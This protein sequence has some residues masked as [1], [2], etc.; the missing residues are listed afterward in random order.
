MVSFRAFLFREAGKV[1][2]GLAWLM[3]GLSLFSDIS[4]DRG[5]WCLL[6]IV[7]LAGIGLWVGACRLDVA[8]KKWKT[9]HS[10]KM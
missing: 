3:G 4:K 8:E 6:G 1:L 5:W 7:A 9:P 10:L 2:V